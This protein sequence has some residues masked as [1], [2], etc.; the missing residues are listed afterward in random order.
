ML[1]RGVFTNQS[2][3]QS[4]AIPRLGIG[5]LAATLPAA[6]VAEGV[7]RDAF[8]RRLMPNRGTGT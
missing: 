1:A 6:K 5:Q 3:H 7:V 2:R 8:Q 4:S